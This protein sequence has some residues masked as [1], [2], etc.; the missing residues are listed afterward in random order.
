[1]SWLIIALRLIYILSPSM[2]Y[3]TNKVL[4]RKEPSTIREH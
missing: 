1:M 2:S 4:N 3:K